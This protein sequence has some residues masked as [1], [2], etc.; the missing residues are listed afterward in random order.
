MALLLLVADPAFGVAALYVLGRG[1]A[2][3]SGEYDE[4]VNAA[5]HDLTSFVMASMFQV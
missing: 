1:R 5:L 4:Y 2:A 3:E